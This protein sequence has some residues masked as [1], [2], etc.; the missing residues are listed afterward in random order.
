MSLGKSV[1]T[2]PAGDFLRVDSGFCKMHYYQFHIGDYRAATAH[3]TN[4]EDLAYRRLLDMYYDTEQPIPADTQWVSRRI[5][6]EAMVV[7]DVLNDMFDRAE[8]GTWTHKR[9]DKEIAK[10]KALEARNK[11]NG[12]KGG[13]PKNPE[14]PSGLPVDSHS[15]PTGKATNN[16]K[17]RTNIN[18]PD[19][20]KPDGVSDSVW[21]EFVS[22]RKA[23]KA[24]VTQLV[25][26]GIAKEAKEAGW[27]LEDALKE[28]I[29]RNW[30]SFK[31]SWV[32]NKSFAFQQNRPNGLA[33]AI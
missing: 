7:R 11:A 29:V 14:K 2:P 12:S 20:D 8:D 33:G 13:R 16:H 23:R 32:T 15:E 25:I 3:L 6:V 5:R 1:Q 21:Q 4:E 18:T 17:P 26:D 31:A 10:Y 30:Q 19:V 27:A 9:A 24:K 28:I 22:H